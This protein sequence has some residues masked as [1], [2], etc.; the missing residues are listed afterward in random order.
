MGSY[1]DITAPGGD[2]V[3]PP[4][5]AGHRQRGHPDLQL[6]RR[7][8]TA[9][10][11][12]HVRGHRRRPDLV[13]VPRLHQRQQPLHPGRRPLHL[14]PTTRTTARPTTRCT[15]GDGGVD[16][17]E[18]ADI[19]VHEYGHSVHDNQVPGLGPGNDTE[20]R[21]IGEGFGDF[22]AGL[23]YI[24]AR[25][26]RLP[27]QLQVLHRRVGRRQLQPGRRRQRRLRLPALDQRPQRGHRRRHR[28]LR[29]HALQEHNDGRFWSAAMT[30]IYEGWTPSRTP[31]TTS[32]SSSSPITSTSSPTRATRLPELDRRP[33]ARG[34]DPVRQRPP[35]ADR[36][37]RREPAGRA[38]HAAG[39]RPGRLRRR[40]RH[41]R[42]GVPPS[43]SA[44]FVLG[45]AAV[46]HGTSGDIPV[47]ADYD[48]DGDVDIAVF[49]PSTGVLVRRNGA[50]APCSG[51][52]GD[53]PVPADYDGDGDADF[54]VFRPSVGG[55]YVAGQSTVFR[56]A[57]TSRCRATTTPTRPTTSPCSGRRSAGW[58]VLGR[59]TVSGHR[60]RHPGAGA[61]RRR[62]LDDVAVFR[63]SA[64][65]WY[66][67]G[68]GTQFSASA[69]TSPCPATTT[70]TPPT[71]SPCSAGPWA[72]GTS[73]AAHRLL[74]PTRRH[75]AAHPQPHLP[76]LHLRLTPALS[77]SRSLLQVTSA[78]R[79]RRRGWRRRRSPRWCGRGPSPGSA[80]TLRT[81][82]T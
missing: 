24:N 38:L 17:A 52:S 25:R 14:R 79:T 41:R 69:A 67:Q 44:W 46:S 45:Q 37:L 56:P 50:S 26:R 42:V 81:R 71:R 31:A 62:R 34:S 61:V 75:A 30:C 65:G 80:R 53:I 33:A 51:A 47:P 72:A 74:R 11:R 19:T 2:R 82:I 10:R 35:V 54:A 78:R 32:W 59:S 6:H 36:H 64:G 5:R 23:Y 55:W 28:H 63:P 9:S 22:L 70:A 39:R 20:Q 49:R 18:D 4:L 16:D 40:R 13:P 43:N 7:P 66:V 48:G 27:G 12:R 60:R 1:V 15:L 77:E 73:R 8:T 58:F 68:R 76:L 3:Q 57:A 29:R 21:A